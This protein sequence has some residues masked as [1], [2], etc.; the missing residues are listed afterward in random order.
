MMRAA[1]ATGEKT[2]AVAAVLTIEAVASWTMKAARV[3]A[4]TEAVASQTRR[5]REQPTTAEA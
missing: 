4:R 3:G 2:E 1:Q 5:A